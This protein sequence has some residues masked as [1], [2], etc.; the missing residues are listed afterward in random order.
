MGLFRQAYPVLNLHHQVMTSLN[1]WAIEYINQHFPTSPLVFLV[2]SCHILLC[3]P[4]NVE[5]SRKVR[6]YIKSV[7][8]WSCNFVLKR[9]SILIVGCRYSTS[10]LSLRALQPRHFCIPIIQSTGVMMGVIPI[11]QSTG[12]KSNFEMCSWPNS[13]TAIWKELDPHKCVFLK[14]QAAANV[15]VCSSD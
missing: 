15:C 2:E 5:K 11:K 12:L 6:A 3:Q 13:P 14:R 9:I 4:S 8:N 1:E 7:L 10:H